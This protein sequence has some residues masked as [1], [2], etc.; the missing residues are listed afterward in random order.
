MSAALSAMRGR[1]LVGRRVGREGSVDVELGEGRGDYDVVNA[2]RRNLQ[3]QSGRG[4]Q[5]EPR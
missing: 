2:I 5:R 4:D 1:V 3:K